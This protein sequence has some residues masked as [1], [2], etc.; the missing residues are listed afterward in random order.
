MSRDYDE[1]YRLAMRFDNAQFESG[2]RE[3]LNT[4]DELRQGLDLEGAADSFKIVSKS[5]DK[6]LDFSDATKSA[7]AFQKAITGVGTAAKSVFN[8]ALSPIR[9]VGQELKTLKNF[10]KMVFGFDI[11]SNLEQ[12]A[13]TTVRAFTSEPIEAGFQE[14]EMK[15][16][17]LKTIMSGSAASYKKQLQDAQDREYAQQKSNLDYAYK[18][19]KISSEEYKKQSEAL[20]MQYDAEYSAKKT[21]DEKVKAAEK[22]YQEKKKTLELELKESDLTKEQKERRRNQ[23]KEELERQKTA[24]KYEYNKNRQGQDLYD[25]DAHREYVKK[26]IEEL[27]EYAD[28]TIYSFRDMTSNI[29]KFVNAGVNL[30]DATAAMKGISN[31]AAYSGQGSSEASR[32][33]YNLSQSMAMGHMELRDWYSIENANMATKDFKDTVISLG[34]AMGTLTQK[35]GKYY[36]TNKET[37]K[38]IEVTANN[39]RETLSYDWLTNDVLLGALKIFSGE[40][41]DLDILK[42]GFTK[43]DPMVE[44]FLNLGK[45]A[46]EAATQVRTFSKMMEALK[47]AAQ[48]GWAITFEKIIGDDKEATEFWT[49]LNNE[50]LSPM[51]ENPAKKRNQI[52]EEWRNFDVGNGKKSDGRKMLLDGLWDMLDTIKTV[53]SGISKAW[54]SIFGEMDAKK[55]F[56]MTKGFR[57]FSGTLKQW[58]GSL[59]DPNSRISK[60]TTGLE[61]LF[62]VVKVGWE[63]VKGVFGWISEK[64]GPVFSW[65]IDKFALV[66]DKLKLLTKKGGFRELLTSIKDAIKSISL[67]DIKGVF[68]GIGT[69][70]SD[71]WQSIRQ[72]V[73][74]WLVNNGLGSV[75]EWFSN[76]KADLTEKWNALVN[77][78][79]NSKIKE[80]LVGMWDSVKDFFTPREEYSGESP[81][82][83]F[84]NDTKKNL[85]EKFSALKSWWDSSNIKAFFG[86]M[87]NAVRDFFT[88][89]EE[90]EGKS[91][92]QK[93]LENAKTNLSAKFAALKLWW[94]TSKIKDFFDGIWVS[95]VD[96]FSP[97]EE[98]EG[99]SS[100]QKFLEDTK[101]NL[102]E[103]F[104]ELKKWWD[105][106]KVKEF[107]EGIW[108]AVTD[109]FGPKEEG[110]TTGDRSFIASIEEKWHAIRDWSGW[111]EISEFVSDSGILGTI[112]NAITS[113]W[114]ALMSFLA[115]DEQQTTGRKPLPENVI[116]IASAGTTD[117][118]FEK[119][120]TVITK[121]LGFVQ[122]MKEEWESAKQTMNDLLSDIPTAIDNF[123]KKLSSF[124]GLGEDSGW[125]EILDGAIGTAG[126]IGRVKML[127]SGAG[128][129]SSISKAV[130]NFA[131]L[132]KI[133]GNNAKNGTGVFGAFKGLIDSFTKNNDKLGEMTTNQSFWEN[134][135]KNFKP[136]GDINI[137]QITDS[138]KKVDAV[139]T[140]VLKFAASVLMIVGA[141]NWLTEINK[142]YEEEDINKALDILAQIMVA[143]GAFGFLSLFGS[144]GSSKFGTGVIKVAFAVW[145][146]TK[147]VGQLA[148][149]SKDKSVDWNQVDGT[150]GGLAAIIGA[151]EFISKLSDVGGIE[152]K[153]KATGLVG[154]VIAL[155]G[156]I[157][158]IKQIGELTKTT[159]ISTVGPILGQL[160]GLIA[161]FE[162]VAKVSEIGSFGAGVKL[163]SKASGLIGF[164][165]AIE[166]MI[167]ALN[168]LGELTKTTDISTV[169]PILGQ[170][171][172]AISAFEF[173]SSISEIG[174]IKTGGTATGLIGFA[175]AVQ[176]LVLA[177]KQIADVDDPA[178]LEK[179]VD[180]VDA[181]GGIINKF[182]VF[183]GLASAVSAVP[184]MFGGT[185]GASGTGLIGFVLAIKG[186]ID[187]VKAIANLGAEKA[188]LGVD[189]VGKLTGLIDSF[190]GVKALGDAAN[191]IFGAF[192]STKQYTIGKVIDFV[193]MEGFVGS[194]IL[195]VN[196]IAD[197]STK[198]IDTTKMAAI[199]ETFDTTSYVITRM[200][201]IVDSFAIVGAVTGNN[202]TAGAQA[203]V[204]LVEF[205]GIMAVAFV[206]FGAAISGIESTFE[207]L[208]I[209]FTVENLVEYIH[210]AASFM[211]PLLE[212]FG[213]LF[214]AFGGGVAGAFD[215]SKMNKATEGISTALSNINGIGDED[216]EK[217][218]ST[219]SIMG[220]ITTAL[221]N[222]TFWELL[223]GT[224][225]DKFSDGMKKLGQGLADMYVSVSEIKDWSK[226]EKAAEIL[227]SLSQ[228]AKDIS[229]ATGS[230]GN[231][232]E[233]LLIFIAQLADLDWI[234]SRNGQNYRVGDVYTSFGEK[235]GTAF[236]EGFKKT[237]IELAT[238]IADN[239]DTKPVITPVL[240]LS[241]F[242]SGIA[243]MNSAIGR[244]F[245]FDLGGA[246]VAPSAAFDMSLIR[247][248][249][250]KNGAES[251]AAVMADGLER[252]ENAIA[253]A[254]VEMDGQ[255]VGR[256]VTP[257]V[258]SN[259]AASIARSRRNSSSF[260]G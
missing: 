52:L 92:F 211:T 206:G 219:I 13:I 249:N 72:A 226:L 146:L 213:S 39:L 30:D 103:K 36:A 222:K 208:G 162:F 109:F 237:A 20:R 199:T 168:Q 40:V 97:K 252:I 218:R 177:V 155:E 181:I 182:E 7:T 50:Y 260:S 194:L 18:Q 83:K 150:L 231:P 94:S 126:D 78:W 229:D 243:Q 187:A 101:A 235:V 256:I 245:A 127:F 43:D 236:I 210:K 79:N 3:S 259:I 185:A 227:R 113:L 138:I 142:N 10:T 232:A 71:S 95:I 193:S 128:L 41:T 196:G 153:G 163:E 157:L 48:S 56:D 23:L 214:G 61:G 225:M 68:S 34:A 4:L 241:E 116:L 217:L 111:S 244:S 151:F 22:E 27:N 69:F 42:M 180:V 248:L 233:D 228:A 183:K 165:I 202:W 120:D 143:L 221:P 159:D 31:W 144:S 100:F 86:S 33:M 67:D 51:I 230:F 175:L 154:F 110:N 176:S 90:Y 192:S 136:I 107:F 170:L 184:T 190:M 191:G 15:M 47:E 198:D 82:Q 201:G 251:T 123:R 186:M 99:K 197:L 98:Y 80:F 114:N 160:V 59:D 179:S 172:M 238:I 134:L 8:A 11:A 149:L 75:S 178:K 121:F 1:L 135:V 70:L 240:D 118:S 220:E 65:L 158:A 130:K 62:S 207:S 26:K 64:L 216:L 53:A 112:T 29:G 167:L 212:E 131:G 81:F 204:N 195:L 104:A 38:Q 215:A 105:E 32:A 166:G 58:F 17:S 145:V 189:L 77:W 91:P 85:S 37:G 21:Y 9:A 19:K 171:V 57:R 250:Q 25:E 164:V 122:K 253:N 239:I 209:E 115:S 257:Y 200:A 254:R 88:P 24:Y 44:Y 124:F 223:A 173:V 49:K 60:I 132:E 12:A 117:F 141:L 139:A 174:S 87:W 246:T 125:G 46:Y 247:E 108:S 54:K 224:S 147:A 137:G 76:V 203:A 205:L 55:L 28:N 255:T 2:V 89:K 74:D 93:F 63:A 258:D 140:A 6:Y 84:L 14:Y 5:A 119:K 35:S 133:F 152:T 16:D 129:V 102:S 96:F 66:G 106:S 188:N 161:A 73:K 169:G 242:N 45:N 156:M 148:E 234:V